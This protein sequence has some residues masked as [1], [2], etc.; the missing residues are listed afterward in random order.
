MVIK[1]VLPNLLNV[2]QIM[3]IFGVNETQKNASNLL[4]SGVNQHE[5]S[6]IKGS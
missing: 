4:N 2:A 3:N 1:S 5:N 6:F